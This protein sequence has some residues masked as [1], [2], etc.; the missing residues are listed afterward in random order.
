MPASTDATTS[1][2]P[3][4]LITGATGGIGAEFARYLAQHGSNLVLTGR[5]TVKLGDIATEVAGFGAQSI[6]LPVDLVDRAARTRM[7]DELTAEGVHISTLVNNAGYG[8]VNDLHETDVDDLLDMVEVNTAALTHLTRLLLPAMLEAKQGSIINVASTASYQP[9]P[10]MGAYAASKAY[11]RSL[12]LAL[13]HETRGTGVRVVCINPG[14]TE[15]GFFTRAGN[16][17]VLRR[18]RS[19]ED[20]VETTFKALNANRPTAIDGVMNQATAM[21]NRFVPESVSTAL[22]KVFIHHT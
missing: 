9:I 4:A 20:V 1:E 6:L 15:T 21:A 17:N 5:N 14:P 3:W 22:A 8:L 12:S 11:V 2:R 7:V 19:P 16:N 13:W 10:S 18:R